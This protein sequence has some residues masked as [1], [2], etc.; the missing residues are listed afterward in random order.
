MIGGGNSG[1]SLG[2][3]SD[4]QPEQKNYIKEKPEIAARLQSLHDE[5]LKDVQPKY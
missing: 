4:A 2:N 1:T 5:W 3:L